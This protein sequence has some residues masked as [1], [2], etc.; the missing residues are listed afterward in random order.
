MTTWFSTTTEDES[1]RLLD[2]WPDAPY[3]ELPEVLSML[4]DSARV[5]VIAFAQGLPE[6]EI[7]DDYVLRNKDGDPVVDIPPRL[8]YAQLQQATNLWN[9]GRKG[10]ADEFGSDTFSFTPRPLDKTVRQLIRPKAVP[11]V[12]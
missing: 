4:L 6:D 7:L 12:V 11:S 8:V 9:A 1:T 10:N 2:S 3:D 5:Q